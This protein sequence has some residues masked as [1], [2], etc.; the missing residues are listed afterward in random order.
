[1]TY[2]L[3]ITL[4]TMVVDLKTDLNWAVFLLPHNYMK[5]SC[6]LWCRNSHIAIRSF[7]ET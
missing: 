3:T 4:V 6:S 5:I 2:I 1:M 7:L